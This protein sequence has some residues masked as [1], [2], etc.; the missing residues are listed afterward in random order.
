MHRNFLVLVAVALAVFAPS[1]AAAQED[2]GTI[3]VTSAELVADT[4]TGETIV[5]RGTGRCAAAGPVLLRVI[6]R[7][8]ET[9]ARGIGRAD[10]RCL[11]PGEIIHWNVQV[12]GTGFRAGDSVLVQVAANGAITDADQKTVILKWQ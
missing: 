12:T 8:L 7:D 9:G 1:T 3:E 10:T 2:T 5:V 6:L 4:L 11:R